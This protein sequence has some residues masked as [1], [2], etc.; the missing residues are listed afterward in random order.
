MECRFIC[1]LRELLQELY[2][3]ID[4]WCWGLKLFCAGWFRVGKKY[5]SVIF[6]EREIDWLCCWF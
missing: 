3:Q 2:Q 6:K 5:S 1:W 4:R